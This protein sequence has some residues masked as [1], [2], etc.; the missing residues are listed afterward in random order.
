MAVD[1]VKTSLQNK[2]HHKSEGAF[3]HRTDCPDRSRA[4]SMS[5]GLSIEMSI[6]RPIGK[7]M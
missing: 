5:I 7:R 6:D 2:L 1:R 4:V 3:H